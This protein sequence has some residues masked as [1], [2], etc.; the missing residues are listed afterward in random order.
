MWH[1]GAIRREWPGLGGTSSSARRRDKG[2]TD[3]CANVGSTRVC[4]KAIE[5]RPGDFS[6]TS[7]GRRC[8]LR[9]PQRQRDSHRQESN[10]TFPIA[11]CRPRLGEGGS[12]QKRFWKPGLPIT[13]AK[14]PPVAD[15]LPKI[16]P[17][18]RHERAGLSRSPEAPS[19]RAPEGRSIVAPMHSLD[20]YELSTPKGHRD[21][22]HRPAGGETPKGPTLS[23]DAAHPVRHPHGSYRP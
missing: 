14:R 12:V 3:R 1:S 23:T 17:F 20:G 22:G 7:F 21:A 13:A 4:K 8:R 11:R 19:R 16:L 6:A 2:A 5:D 9:A 10:R 15:P 18:M